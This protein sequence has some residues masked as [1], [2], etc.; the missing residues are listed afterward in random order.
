MTPIISLIIPVYNTEKYL[1][2]CI[3]SLL[4]QTFKDFEMILVD[5]GSKD[6]SGQ[7]CDEYAQKDNRIR[8][9]HKQNGGV[10]KARNTGID[11]AKGRYV[12]FCDADDYAEPQWCEILYKHIQEHPKSWCFCGCHCVDANGEYTEKNCVLHKEPVFETLSMNNYKEVYETNYSSLL[13]N[14]IFDL[15]VIR[16]NN[17]RFDERMSVSEDVLFNLHYGAFCEEFAVVNMPLYNHRVYLNDEVE[18]LDGK[19][20]KEMFYINQQVYK[21]RGKLIVEQEQESFQTDYFYRFIEDISAL[22]KSEEYTQIEKIKK[23]ARIV[24]SKEF[25]ECLKNADTSKE[26][27]KFLLVMRCKNP[28]LIYQ[29]FKRG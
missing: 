21:A 23:I 26:S 10:S 18:H 5:D 22:A 28:I 9:I 3:E 12:L 13:W 2:G 24:N 8:V 19:R 15:S 27:K 4:Q 14:R 20:P 29:M 7:I 16:A 17:I 6:G 11:A 1:A 25:Q